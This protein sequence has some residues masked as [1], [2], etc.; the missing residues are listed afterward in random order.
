MRSIRRNFK[1]PSE[2]HKTQR[3][4]AVLFLQLFNSTILQPVTF[5]LTDILRILILITARHIR[6]KNLPNVRRE[7]SIFDYMLQV[8]QHNL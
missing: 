3:N 4:Y 1:G 6:S 7:A 8:V 2:L 5:L